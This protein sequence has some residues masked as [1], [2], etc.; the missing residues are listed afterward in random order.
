[1]LQFCKCASP[2]LVVPIELRELVFLQ[3]LGNE[4]LL[5]D[6]PV[7]EFSAEVVVSS[8]IHNLDQ[9]IAYMDNGG[10][11]CPPTEVIHKPKNIFTITLKPVG[12][13]CR[14]RFLE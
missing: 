7:N 10:V 11:K 9:A 4:D 3:D 1:M 8:V 2:F 12:K 14:N 13:R 6:C 5:H